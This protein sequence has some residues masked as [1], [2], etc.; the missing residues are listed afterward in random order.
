MDIYKAKTKSLSGTSWREIYSK[1]LDFYYPIKSKT[2]RRPYIRSTYYNKQKI[3]LE[4]FWQHLHEKENYR[5]KIR[6]L[7]LFPVALELISSSRVNP[8]TKDNPNRKDELL[9]KFSGITK[10]GIQFYVHIKENKRSGEK[11]LMSVFPK[12]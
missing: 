11:W 10:D 2:K 6:R 3:F 9:H 12:K 5:D 1:V 7:K 8:T 4:L